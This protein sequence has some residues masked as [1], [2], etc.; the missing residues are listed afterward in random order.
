MM[1][2]H[3]KVTYTL[4]RRSIDIIERRSFLEEI[5]KSKLLSQCIQSGYELMI[6]EYYEYDNQPRIGVLKKF[7]NT[8]P[9]TFSLPTDVEAVLSYFSEELNLKKSHLVIGCIENFDRI[10]SQKLSQQIDD[11]MKF[12]TVDNYYIK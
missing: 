5:S 9:K 11:L 1:I 4:D 12:V 7:K 8:I 3:K 2:K 10:E 6:E